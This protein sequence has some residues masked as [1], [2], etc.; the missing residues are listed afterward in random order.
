MHSDYS[1]QKDGVYIDDVGIGV[2]E[3]IYP[4]AYY[5][6]TSMA[7]PQVTGAAGLVA[8]AFPG[9]GTTD[10]RTRLLNGTQPMADLDGAVATGGTLNLAGVL[11]DPTADGDADSVPD[12]R[13]NCAAT[14][15][16]GQTDTDIDGY[17]N[18]CDCDLDNNGNVGMTDFTQF[19]NAWG[20]SEAVA[21]FDGD[22]N[23]G[24]ADFMIL[25]GRWGTSAP[26]E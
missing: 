14:A 2:P 7:T 18:A 17:G 23:V 11:G 13:D 25:Q 3:T 6:G 26:F 21:D 1:I 15:N 10:I 22:G 20:S 9:I 4:Y 24:M 12:F 16:A 8:A 19:S 5:S